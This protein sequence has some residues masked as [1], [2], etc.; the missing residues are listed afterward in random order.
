MLIERGRLHPEH[1]ST[2]C[3]TEF[4]KPKLRTSI[5][6]TFHKRVLCPPQCTQHIVT[7]RL[8][9]GISKSENR[10]VHCR[11]TAQWALFPRKTVR[12]RWNRRVAWEWKHVPETTRTW[13]VRWMPLRETEPFEVSSRPVVLNLCETAARLIFFIRQGPGT[14][15]RSGGWE[16]LF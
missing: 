9:A 10:D 4:P 3:A 2:Q 14:G 15:P 16:T 1:A 12:W 11:A 8:K 13:P 7:C 6:S 5:Y